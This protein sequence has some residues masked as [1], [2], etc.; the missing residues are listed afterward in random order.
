M[1]NTPT[2]QPATPLRPE[3]PTR[4][5]SRDGVNAARTPNTPFNGVTPNVRAPGSFPDPLS[6]TYSQIYE[7]RLLNPPARHG[8][9]APPPE[10]DGR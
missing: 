7:T 10:R 1:P 4:P 6:P 8:A 5:L 2:T 9:I 3:P